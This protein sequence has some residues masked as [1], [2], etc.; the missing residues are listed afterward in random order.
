MNKHTETQTFPM[1]NL[2]EELGRMNGCKYFGKCDIAMAFHQIKMF[3][4]D[5]DKTAFTAGFQK[6][7]F[8]RMP[9]GL[10]GSPITWQLY[11]T[12]ILVSLITSNMMVYMDDILTYSRTAEGHENTLGK[13]FGIF[14]TNGLKLK[15][16]KTVL[17]AKEV[18]YLGH[19]IG[20][21]G[22]KPNDRN[23]KTIKN[24]PRPKKLAEVQRFSGMASYFRKFIFQ[25]AAKAQPLHRLCKKNLDFVWS[26][27][28]ETAFQTLKTALTTAPV[29][30]FP[31]Y[32]RI[33]KC[34]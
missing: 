34:G 30:V 26:E 1:P 31:D 20:D 14:R 10:K 17:F 6:F 29:L 11:L 33:T 24:C 18:E 19:V 32:S 15:I 13:L 7:Q 21:G 16:E 23:I 27:A 28:C 4:G 2:E 3:E 25:F 9:F 8:K 5:K 22:L 12:T